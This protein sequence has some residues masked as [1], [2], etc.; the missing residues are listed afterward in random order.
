[1]KILVLYQFCKKK[2]K[3]NRQTLF[4]MFKVTQ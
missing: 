1:M 2:K 4:V 3:K